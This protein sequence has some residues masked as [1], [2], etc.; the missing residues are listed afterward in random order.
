[1]VQVADFVGA[2]AA[3]QLEAEKVQGDAADPA[4]PVLAAEAAV[5]DRGL[6][7][8]LQPAVLADDRCLE[9]DAAKVAVPDQ[10]RLR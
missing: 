2:D 9:A 5:G 6:G 3:R 1:M 7:A 4:L 10:R 8:V